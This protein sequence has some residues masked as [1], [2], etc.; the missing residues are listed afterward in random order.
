MS[1]RSDIFEQLLRYRRNELPPKEKAAMERRLVKDAEVREMLGL[2]D[3]LDRSSDQPESD[4]AGAARELADRIFRD[5]SLRRPQSRVPVGVT[6]FDSK[7]LPIPAG[8]RPAAVDTRQVRFRIDDC[9]VILMLYPV[10]PDSYEIMGQIGE[11]LSDSPLSLGLSKR[12]FRGAATTDEF[13]L[14]RFDRV[15]LGAYR[16]TVFDGTR[17]LGLIH[18]TI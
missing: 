6:V 15:P 2:L 11:G 3:R 12:G 17:P 4:I 7:L 14:F 16:L 1:I 18:V 9:E 10:A 13:G 8:V 5:Y